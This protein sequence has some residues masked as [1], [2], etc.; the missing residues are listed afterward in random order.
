M[1]G[2]IARRLTQTAEDLAGMAPRVLRR[3]NTTGRIVGVT[4]QSRTCTPGML[5]LLRVDRARLS[6]HSATH[7]AARSL[8]VHKNT[9]RYRLKRANAISGTDP[10]DPYRPVLLPLAAG[11][12]INSCAARALIRPLPARRRSVTAIRSLPSRPI[13]CR[14]RAS[15]ATA[16]SVRA[17]A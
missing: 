9:L 13:P 16:G 2:R 15:A 12:R 7:A 17:P 11:N 5:R 10:T 6:A 1:I 8:Y 14:R 4:G 3:R